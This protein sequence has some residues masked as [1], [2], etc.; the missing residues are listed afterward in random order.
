ME[1][2]IALGVIA[3]AVPLILATTTSGARTR[4]QAEADTRSAWL[5]QDLQR[6]LTDSWKNIPSPAFVTKP[7]F[8]QFSSPES[9]TVLLFDNEG[10][11]LA[12]GTS[13]EYTKGST[14][15]K[16]FYLVALHGVSQ[17][18]FNITGGGDSMSKVTI[19]VENSAR[20]A[21]QKRTANSFVV[22]IPRQTSP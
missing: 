5:A 8:P 11:F 17:T 3:V 1:A 16:A 21:K 14:N 13:E 20:A 12:S 15:P 19:S 6:Q 9:P 18:A 4:V 22:L 10:A 7:I 2:V